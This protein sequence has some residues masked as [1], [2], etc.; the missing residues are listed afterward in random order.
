MIGP[1]RPRKLRRPV[2]IGRHLA[3]LVRVKSGHWEGR[4]GRN[5]T[6][7]ESFGK[8]DGFSLLLIAGSAK[9]NENTRPV[10]VMDQ[11][12]VYNRDIFGGDNKN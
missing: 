11:L 10:C 6:G 12:C 9:S 1:G 2:W 7:G 4:K 5:V 3:W 8:V